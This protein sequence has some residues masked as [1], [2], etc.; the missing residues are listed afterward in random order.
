MIILFI[1]QETQRLAIWTRRLSIQVSNRTG[2]KI[3]GIW[4]CH[5]MALKYFSQ[6]S[7]QNQIIIKQAIQKTELVIVAEIKQVSEKH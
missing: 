3:S 5:P 6:N 2:Q 1:G 7:R 4:L